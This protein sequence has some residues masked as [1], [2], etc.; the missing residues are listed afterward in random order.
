[1]QIPKQSSIDWQALVEGYNRMY[2]TDFADEVDLLE[3]ICTEL[4]ARKLATQLGIGYTT[5]Y[6]RLDLHKIPRSHTRGGPN[7]KGKKEKEFLAISEE[8]M[9]HL[10]MP[11]I[12]RRIGICVGYGFQLAKKNGRR[13]VPRKGSVLYKER[14]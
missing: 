8:E 10:T 6:Y 11:Q 2:S 5:I 1:M 4:S 14:R 3:S 9:T 7:N 12:A 13:F